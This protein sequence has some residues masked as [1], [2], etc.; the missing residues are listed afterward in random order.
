MY[1]ALQPTSRA[2]RCFGGENPILSS[3]GIHS[4]GKIDRCKLILNFELMQS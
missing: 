1:I 3:T 4:V 2:T